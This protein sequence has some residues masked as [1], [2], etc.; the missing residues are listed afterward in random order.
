M[1]SPYFDRDRRAEA[2]AWA[3][4]TARVAA[5]WEA[6]AHKLREKAERMAAQ[7]GMS[8]DEVMARRSRLSGP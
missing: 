7:A 3:E 1:P 5:E 4:K 8:P 6:Y 2:E